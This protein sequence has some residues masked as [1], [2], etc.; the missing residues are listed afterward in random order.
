M[1]KFGIWVGIAFAA[2]IILYLL[3]TKGGKTKGGAII[4]MTEKAAPV[5]KKKKWNEGGT[6]HKAT[7][8]EWKAGS[9]ADRLATCADFAARI[10]LANNQVFASDK[11]WA[12][13]AYYFLAFLDEVGKKQEND[14]EKVAE[15]VAAGQVLKQKNP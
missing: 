7:L 2:I 8:A 9:E 6:L 4:P 14:N 5:V 11:E 3:D 13:D 12:E 15:L 1:K 10:K